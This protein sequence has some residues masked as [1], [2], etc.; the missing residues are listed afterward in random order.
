[1]QRT[2]LLPIATLALFAACSGSG[3]PPTA[4]EPSLARGGSTSPADKGSCGPKDELNKGNEKHCAPGQSPGNSNSPGNSG[5][6]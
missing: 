3:T 4:P 6:P 5:N 2:L 1:M